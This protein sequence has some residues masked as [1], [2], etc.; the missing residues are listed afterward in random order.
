MWF[1]A[2]NMCTSMCLFDL[3]LKVPVD[4]N[5]HVGTL[6]AFQRPISMSTEGHKIRDRALENLK[7]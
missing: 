2:K 4:S 3:R 5:D 1:I 6:P 7:P